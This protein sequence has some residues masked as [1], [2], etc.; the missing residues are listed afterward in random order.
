MVAFKV[1]IGLQTRFFTGDTLAGCV[2]QAIAA[3]VPVSAIKAGQFFE[4]VQLDSDSKAL[5]LIGTL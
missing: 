1:D 4:A 5:A 2:R 3:Q